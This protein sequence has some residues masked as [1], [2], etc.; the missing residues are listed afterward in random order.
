MSNELVDRF[1]SALAARDGETMAACYHDDIV[2]S[3]PAFGELRGVDAGDMWRMLCSSDTNLSVTHGIDQMSPTSGLAHWVAEYTFTPTGRPVRN[4]ISATMTF[5]DG[6]IVEH[7][8][9]FD[10]WKWSRQALGTPGMLLGWSPLL[11]AKVRKTT[12]ANLKKFQAKKA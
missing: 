4:E 9:V 3:D 8:D 1:Y 10:F 6:L 2:F 7:H 5:R 11:K 12:H